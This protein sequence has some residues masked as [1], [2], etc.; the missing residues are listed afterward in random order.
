[1]CVGR[2]DERA[3]RRG[4]KR[5]IRLRVDP[6]QYYIDVKEGRAIYESLN[7]VVRRQ[8]EENNFK[9]VLG[10]LRDLLNS[11]SVASGASL[12]SW[13]SELMLG[14]GHPAAAHYK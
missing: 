7:L 9:S 14:Y 5:K 3:G 13:L 8:P 11:P 12:P 4:T 6:A 10:T 2:P 1:M